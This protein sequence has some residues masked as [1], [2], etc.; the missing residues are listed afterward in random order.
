MA[1][2]KCDKCDRYWNDGEP[3]SGCDVMQI[4]TCLRCKDKGFFRCAKGHGPT[5]AI[6]LT[7]TLP[8]QNA[9]LNL[10]CGICFHEW[11][12]TNFGSVAT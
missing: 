1:N 4:G 10:I 11:S 2:V 5:A 9:R 7:T 3:Y 12:V 6:Q 8:G